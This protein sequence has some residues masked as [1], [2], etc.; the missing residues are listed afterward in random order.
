M[1]DVSVV[2]PTWNRAAMLERAVRSALNQTLPPLEILVC[3]DGSSDDSRA[4]IEAMG[5]S[6]VR[7]IDGPRAGRP[8]IPRNR[9]IRE[10]RGEWIAF[11]DDDD[12]WRPEKLER[13]LALAKQLECFA[14]CTNAARNVPGQVTSGA[15]LNWQ[16]DRITFGDLL[17]VN[18]VVCS[19]AMVH[20]SLFENAHGFP[21]DAQLRVGEDFALWLRI[22]SMTDFAFVADQLVVYRDDPANS[23]RR[24]AVDSWR[25]RKAVFASFLLWSD[26]AT[27]RQ[28]H[29]I[30]VRRRIVRDRLAMFAVTLRA[31]FQR[32]IRAF[33][34]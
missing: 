6:R 28:H 5:E 24:G 25:Q 2:I 26:E 16:C 19:S 9:G 20:Q 27:G 17:D 1:S 30:T 4:V 15:Y 31:P 7:W 29:A 34:G 13:Q 14:I 23:I 3:D 33:F 18:H 11:L 21:E 32:V 22:A 8:A 12:E 10:S